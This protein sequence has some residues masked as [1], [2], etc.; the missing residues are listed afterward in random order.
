MFLY[1]DDTAILV[2]GDNFVGIKD[3]LLTELNNVSKWMI[4]HRL[5]LN[6]DKTK[7]MFFGTHNRLAKITETSLPFEN[8][9]VEIVDQFKYLGSM[10]D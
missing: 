7:A 5:S 8:S 1:A 10:L 9:S 3:K 4:D 6:V 2:R